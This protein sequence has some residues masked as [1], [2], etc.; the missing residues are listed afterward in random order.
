VQGTDTPIDG[1]RARRE[2]GR[3]A[4]IDAVFSLADEGKVPVT[5]ELVA[6]RSGVSVASI[7]RYF[8][9]L[10]DLQYQAY[11]RFRER[12]VPLV[13]VVDDG[14]RGDRITGFVASRV[15]LYEQA[16]AMMTLGRLRALEHQPLLEA[17]ADTKAALAAQVRGTF[18]SETAGAS[19]SRTAELVAVIDSFTSLES[20][21]VMTKT[22]A[23]S[24]AQI[25]RSWTRGLA[26][27]IRDWEDEG[28]TA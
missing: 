22:H 15:D 8:D 23:R 25:T 17:S 19:P 9:G 12:F 21:D 18:S 1:R 3:T 6:E 2:R 14:E 13:R 27:L 20:W 7:F 24:R 10:A 26:V 4:V 5:A 28:T 16:G 11:Q